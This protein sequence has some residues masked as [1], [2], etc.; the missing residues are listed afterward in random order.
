MIFD[1]LVAGILNP[2]RTVW[3]NAAWRD[4]APFCRPGFAAKSSSSAPAR[5]PIPPEAAT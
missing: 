2:G 3:Y 1:N 5:G 4:T